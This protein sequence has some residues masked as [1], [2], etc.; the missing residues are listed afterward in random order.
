MRVI[1]ESITLFNYF[2]KLIPRL[3]YLQKDISV[4]SNTF[5]FYIIFHTGTTYVLSFCL[6]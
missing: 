5:P 3:L 4:A 2:A 1:R 6:S